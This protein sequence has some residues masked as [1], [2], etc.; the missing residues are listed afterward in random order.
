MRLSVWQKKSGKTAYTEHPP[1]RILG[2]AV[3]PDKWRP[4][5]FFIST[6]CPHLV[7]IRTVPVARRHLAPVALDG[8]RTGRNSNPPESKGPHGNGVVNYWPC[9]QA[10]RRI[11]GHGQAMATCRRADVW[12][13]RVFGRISDRFALADSRD[14]IDTIFDRDSNH[15]AGKEC[16][17]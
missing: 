15:S 1:N 8:C 3:L 16:R 10:G 14:G 6:T 13:C 12:T 4:C 2:A 17:L 7:V 5:N 11:C 9:R